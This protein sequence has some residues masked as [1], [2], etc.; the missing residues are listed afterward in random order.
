MAEA[1]VPICANGNTTRGGYAWLNRR[2]NST[3]GL[4]TGTRS[5]A[6]LRLLNVP[7]VRGADYTTWN[8]AVSDSPFADVLCG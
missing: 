7:A 4:D 8:L 6:E 1:A 2:H 5:G 3:R